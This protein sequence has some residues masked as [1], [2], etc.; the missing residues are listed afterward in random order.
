M[1]TD[2]ALLLISHDDRCPRCGRKDLMIQ[3]TIN[4]PPINIQIA[5]QRSGVEREWNATRRYCQDCHYIWD[6][7]E[8][9][10]VL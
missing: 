8:Y 10:R 3:G 9:M 5:D 4:D 1:I 2:V 7:L 6:F